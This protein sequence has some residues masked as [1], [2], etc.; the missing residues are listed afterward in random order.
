[1]R[2]AR[3]V[4][5][6]RVGPRKHFFI[7]KENRARDSNIMFRTKR[8]FGLGLRHIRLVRVA[9]VDPCRFRRSLL[10]PRLRP[11]TIIGD[12][13]CPCMAMHFQALKL[14][15]RKVQ[16]E[17]CREWKMG[18][19]SGPTATGSRTKRDTSVTSTPPAAR[20]TTVRGPL[21]SLRAPGERRCIAGPLMRGE[22]RR[23]CSDERLRGR[24]VRANSFCGNNLPCTYSRAI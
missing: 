19:R 24:K 13:E 15:T 8:I 20:E 3:F 12:S 2:G 14:P 10:A 17:G 5:Q 4:S 22:P 21:T 11:S 1:M 6:R 9:G 23:I 16:L 7:E 18:V